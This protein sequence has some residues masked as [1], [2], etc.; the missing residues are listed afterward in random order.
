M[1]LKH[2]LNGCSINEITKQ[3]NKVTLRFFDGIRGKKITMSYEGPIFETPSVTL[4]SR[5]IRAELVSTVGFK[6]RNQLVHQGKNPDLYK[7]LLI[8]LSG[9]TDAYKNE[10][11]CAFTD[12]QMRVN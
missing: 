11:I 1:E 9:S 10:I 8:V 12:Y 6:A 7:Q 4:N 3:G 2:N 5:V